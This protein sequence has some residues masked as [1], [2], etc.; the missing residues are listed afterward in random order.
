[1][2]GK[3]DKIA[4]QFIMDNCGI[5]SFKDY[6]GYPGN[7]C[8]SLNDE[9]IHGIPDDK[10]IIKNG[11]LISIDVGVE[12]DGY[13]G[14]TAHTFIVGGNK[15]KYQRLI[16]CGKRALEDAVKE[17]VAGNRVGDISAAI[18]KA[19]EDNG[20]DVV[21]D[22]VGHGVGR[23]V[24]E[25][26]QIPNYGKSGY[27]LKIKEGYIFALEPMIVADNYRVRVEADDWTVTTIDGGN[28]VHFEHTVAVTGSGPRIL[29]HL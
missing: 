26:P 8:I 16:N 17:T 19:A 5:P 25:D 14:D 11:D 1:S 13:C 27:G 9:V 2:T 6:M 3:L 29:S 12:K 24:H 22:F 18:Q 4:R 28:S 21:R 7:I 20:F 15:K 10:R 23:S